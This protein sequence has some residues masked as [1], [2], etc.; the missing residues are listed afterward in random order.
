MYLAEP[1]INGETHYFIRESF[2]DGDSFR[3]RDLFNLGTNPA[4][5]VVYPGGN[6]YYIDDVV[7]DKLSSLG[8][9]VNADDME[10]LFWP[11]LKPRIRRIH[12][13]FR[14][15]TKAR[16]KRRGIRPEQ[17]ELIRTWVSD[18]DKRRVHY[19]RFGALDQGR[20]GQMPVK[21]Y[22]WVFAKSRDEIEQRFMK[23]ELCLRPFELKTYTY[24][25]FDLQRFFTESWANKIP[26]G[27]DQDKMDK[28]FIEEICRLN[29]DAS[30]WGGDEAGNFSHE[31]LIRYVVMFFDNDYAPDTFLQ[32]YIKEFMDARRSRRTPPSKKSV[33]IEAAS[34]IFGVKEDVLMTMT[35][36][37][38]ARLY[39]RVAKRLHPD[40]GGTHEEF[41]QLTEA[42]H[43]LLRT[44]GHHAR[45]ST[46]R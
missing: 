1:K 27:L 9:R 41:V 3:S 24:T 31:F 21:L 17:E 46:K 36:R 4:R 40:K 16:R 22:R 10:D 29:S 6:A 11:F 20:I 35:K 7:E 43:E 26:Q 18:F 39:R 23:M 19:L 32:D 15:K 28:L 12:E 30:F 2:K 5:Y 45:W 42:Y 44:K 8:T 34:G 33:S 14:Q 37:G 13:S 25:I 38:L